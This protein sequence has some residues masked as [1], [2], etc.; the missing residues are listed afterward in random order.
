MV[1]LSL[2][3]LRYPF[4]PVSSQIP[5]FL[6]TRFPGSRKK[7][8]PDKNQRSQHFLE[9]TEFSRNSSICILYRI[10]YKCPPCSPCPPYPSCPPCPLSPPCLPCPPWQWQWLDWLDLPLMTSHL[11][12][13]TIWSYWNDFRHLC[14]T[15]WT[16]M[17]VLSLT[18]L[19]LQHSQSGAH[20]QHTK[21]NQF[22]KNHVHFV[23]FQNSFKL[24]P[25]LSFTSITIAMHWLYDICLF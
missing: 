22:T 17:L 3:L 19:L 23:S 7:C 1:S 14:G 8:Y 16:G 18:D 25:S 15:G 20:K 11:H 21:N 10:L 2:S 4:R 9:I 13:K 5:H 12:Y 24:P 6:G